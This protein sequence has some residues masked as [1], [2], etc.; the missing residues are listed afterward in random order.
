MWQ[1]GQAGTHF[2]FPPACSLAG[3][4]PRIPEN[5]ALRHRLRAH[6]GAIFVA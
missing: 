4:L 1:A 3:A 2:G 6:S 5:D